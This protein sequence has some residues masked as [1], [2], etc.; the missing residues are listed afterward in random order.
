MKQKVSALVNVLKKNKK[1]VSLLIAGML[2]VYA[3]L[4]GIGVRNAHLATDAALNIATKDCLKR[5]ISTKICSNLK[6][7]LPDPPIMGGDNWR[8]YVDSS[9]CRQFNASMV[10]YTN[11]IRAKISGY[12]FYK[13]VGECDGC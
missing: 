11:V 5:G 10:I 1:D 7:T 12:D 13:C 8:T 3:M 4:W 6:V 9:D 2:L